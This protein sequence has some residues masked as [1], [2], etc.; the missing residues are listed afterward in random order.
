MRRVPVPL[1]SLGLIV[2]LLF[3]MPTSN[4]VL[5]QV[6]VATSTLKGKVSDQ[7]DAAVS[8]ATITAINIARGVERSVNTDSQGAF[9]VPLLQPGL[10]DL[11][12]EATGFQPRLFRTIALTVGQIVVYDV[13]LGVGELREE[14]SAAIAPPMIET[15]RSQQSHTIDQEQITNLPNLSRSFTSYIS[16]LSGVADAEAARVQQT[17]VV[18]LRTSGFSVGGSNGRSNY[19][20]IDGGEN[21]SGS[22]GL[23]VRNLSVEAVQEF[24][25]NLNAF[26][27][28]YGFTAGTAVNVVTRSGT[29]SFHSSGYVFYRSEKFA[30]RDPLNLTGEKAH[31]RRVVPGITFG[32]PL[33]RNKAFVF[34]SFEN[35]RYDIARIRAYTSN[36]S[37]LRPTGPQTAY[38]QT[39]ETGPSATTATRAIALQLRTSLSALNHPHT[40]RILR[41]SEG[42][43]NA[44]SR[45]YN[46]TTRLDYNHGE[47]DFFNGRF[48][49]ALEDNDLLSGNN[50]ESV[51]AGIKETLDDYTAVGSW[52][53][54]FSNS[55]VNQFR[56]QFAVDDY[57]QTSPAPESATLVVAGLINYGRLT[58]LPLIIDQ[59]RYQFDDVLSW[60][61]GDHD[62]KFG[63]SY[64]PIDA[65]LVSEIGF[66]GF[67]Q[68]AGGLPLTRAVAPQDLSVLTGPLTPPADTALTSLQAFSLGLP[69]IWQQG[70]GNPSVKAWQHNLGAFGQ[71]SWKVTPRLTLD[72]GSRL[73]YD[74]EPEPFDRNIS[75]SPRIGFAWDAFGKGRTVIRGGMGTFY[76]PVGL[77][78]LLAATLQSGNGKFIN[79]PSRTLQ[80]GTQSSAAL[81]AHGVNLG[82]LPF[83]ALSEADVSA[84]GISIGPNQP[85][86]RIVDAA[87]DYDNPY[88]VQASLG[89][90][91]QL[92]RDLALELAVQMYHGVHLPVALETNY[93][94][95]GQFVNV[96][97][98]PGSDLFG[99]RLERIDPSLSQRL[100]HTSEG[101]S[102]YYGMTSSLLKRFTRRSQFRVSYTYSK[103]IDDVLDFSG[104]VAPYLPTRRFL[105]RG[106]SAYD[107][108]HSFVASGSFDSPFKAG[109]EQ[110]WTARALAGITLSPIVT[111]RSGFPF[112]LYIGRDVNG[113]IN[114]TDR[115]FYA[116]R[117]SGRG[118]NFYSVDLR[119][120][121]R[122]FL[123]R[124]SEG[125][126]AEFIVEVTN[127]LNRA[128]FL[129]VND[130][131]CG[132]AA[133]PGFINGCDP[134]FL[135]GPF[136]FRGRRDLPPTAPLGFVTAA[137][138][139]QFQFGLK[140]E[141]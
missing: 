72:L 94:E 31:E 73:N 55:I 121:K 61:R 33:I 101:N 113:D 38:L 13:K 84:F 103:A 141:L 78:I 40:M 65:R 79:I 6:D 4:S 20:S 133:Q 108:R 75:V 89:L 116:P 30:A 14:V 59:K 49:I 22:G 120:S 54:I 109:P 125:P 118:E 12:V 45:A 24:Q 9:H 88:T 122:F 44:P 70:F 18:S 71:V 92:W 124:N 7:F 16:T 81:W 2:V 66:G 60:N 56:A 135:T 111:M 107:V 140:L 93:R 139:R 19:I 41:E 11:R 69:A 64:R 27:A 32:G 106:L 117:N 23:R 132:T 63:V 86:R 105:E 85:N 1:S 53:H 100:L 25:V 83:T 36:E 102:I 67:Y 112:N 82:R 98:M 91:Q 123:R 47:R 77:Q 130:T 115:P 21:D 46:W 136:D 50:A 58:T 137:P 114:T 57:R 43:F 28:E 126:R 74:G 80:D 17:R 127:L 26:A 87:S 104:S 48:T 34:T 95:S 15:A 51:S 134:K 8:G 110:H 5:A 37:L 97:G 10:Y 68:F 129:R 42:Q 131:V 39:L 52:G 128:N 96:P 35:I 99:P 62:F 29:N 76:A 119:L 138:P 90:S 3:A